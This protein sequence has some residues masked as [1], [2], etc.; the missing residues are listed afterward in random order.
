MGKT[1]RKQISPKRFAEALVRGATIEEAALRAGYSQTVAKRGKAGISKG[2]LEAYQ[3]A[4]NKELQKLTQIGEGVTAQQQESLVRGK[5]VQNVV[6]GKDEAA[7]S[8]KMLGQ[9]RRVNMFTPESA[10]GIVII[11]A[12]KNLPA[13]PVHDYEIEGWPPHQPEGLPPK[14]AKE[15]GIGV[16]GAAIR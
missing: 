14:V 1:S 11:E 10:T 6:E 16:G 8:L 2:C 7:H 12:P 13:L 5:L 3:A 9:D 4:M 15:L